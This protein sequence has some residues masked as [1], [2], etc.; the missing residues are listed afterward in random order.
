MMEFPAVLFSVI[1]V[2]TAGFVRGYSGF[3]FSMIVV[4]TLSL[5]FTPSRIVPV[6]LLL[7]VAASAW[8]LP[9]IWRQ[10]QWRFLAI[11]FLGVAIGTPMGVY[12]LSR[13]PVNPM[14]AAIAVAVMI[15]ALLLWKGFRLKK[16]PGKTSIFSG[17]IVSGILNGGAAIGGPPAVLLFFSSP[18]S[19][20]VSR[21]S[22]ITF[23]LGTDL[24]AA[25]LCAVHGLLSVQTV[26]IA[27]LLLAPLFLGLYLGNRSFI[28]TPPEAFR[29]RVLILLLVLA[30]ST[31]VRSFYDSL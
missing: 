18:A 19:V 1:V 17:G 14:R 13:I 15:L 24:F 31:L 25:A 29:K 2:L 11:L 20:E 26:T 21:A 9:R 8:M 10:V 4:V 22:L 30:F 23:F 7:E 12:L 5:L 16:M 6:V 3:G 27:A 28:H